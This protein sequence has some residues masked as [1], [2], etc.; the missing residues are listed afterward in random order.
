MCGSEILQA[1]S[2]AHDEGSRKI[3]HR[4]LFKVLSVGTY[5][6]MIGMM[7]DEPAEFVWASS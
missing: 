7:R 3:G 5:F 6:G 4:K 1:I 2:R